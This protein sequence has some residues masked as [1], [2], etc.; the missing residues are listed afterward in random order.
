[1]V[2]GGVWVQWLVEKA[3]FLVGFGLFKVGYLLAEGQVVL[4]GCLMQRKYV[5]VG[6]AQLFVDV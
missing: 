6:Y 3:L 4:L 5:F 1:M 2:S